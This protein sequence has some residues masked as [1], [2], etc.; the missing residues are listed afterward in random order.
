MADD[1]PAAA[2]PF[3]AG[4]ALEPEPPGTSPGSQLCPPIAVLPHPDVA[5]A[6]ASLSLSFRGRVGIAFALVP[7][8]PASFPR[9]P[10]YPPPP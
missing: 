3:V 1:D 6:A 5:A 9:Q 2:L 8:G 4:L 7:G 10:P